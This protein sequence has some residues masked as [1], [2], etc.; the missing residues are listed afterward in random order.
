V[1][2]MKDLLGA[3][4]QSGMTTSTDKRMKN[5]LSAGGEAP[6]SLPSKLSGG[7]SGGGLDDALSQ[8]FG[9][10]IGGMLGN[11]LNDAGQAV[12]GKRNLA[13]GGIGALAGA[14]FGGGRRSMGGAIGAGVMA[15]LGAMA[16]SALKKGGQ[17]SARLPAGLQEAET[18]A[19]KQALEREAGLIFQAM[20]NAAKA[21]GQIDKQEVNRIVDKLG[22]M[23]IDKEAQEF[24]IAEMQKPM[25]TDALVQA[26]EGQP[27][28]GAQ[29]YAASLLAIEVDTTA[30]RNYLRTF[31]E[32]LG[33][34]PA[35]TAE[36]E[37][38]IGLQHT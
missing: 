36:L 15:L 24:L 9:G 37:R 26:D 23:G 27:G 5:A 19:E 17:S 2:S 12:G 14:L 35:V 18:P 21:D 3:F 32:R 38:T 20:I 13:I 30:E 4:T 11:V 6:D 25:D 33:L 7:F 31:G 34:N 28:L 22:E 1:I 8:L 16:Y 10:G 29:L